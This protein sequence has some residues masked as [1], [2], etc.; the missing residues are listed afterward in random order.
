MMN[1]Q[2]YLRDCAEASMQDYLENNKV[3]PESEDDYQR[4]VTAFV[5]SEEEW[6][7]FNL[8]SLNYYHFQELL[9]TNLDLCE[10]HHITEQPEDIKKLMMNYGFYWI[11]QKIDYYMDLWT[12][13]I[14]M[15]NREQ[16]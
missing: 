8:T 12:A 6:W 5:N 2:E 1:L 14:D 4:W 7:D 3:N 11:N 16:A 15:L 10:E 13:N 9:G